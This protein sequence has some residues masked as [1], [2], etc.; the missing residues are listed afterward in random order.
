ME[1]KADSFALRR[2]PG[3]AQEGICLLSKFVLNWDAFL[4]SVC[5]LDEAFGAKRC[6]TA[7]PESGRIQFGQPRQPWR[8]SLLW[9][10]SLVHHPPLQSPLPHHPQKHTP[11]RTM[12]RPMSRKPSSGNLLTYLLTLSRQKPP[13]CPEELPS[14]SWPARETGC[15]SK[16]LSL[17]AGSLPISSSSQSLY[18]RLALWLQQRKC[19]F[20]CHRQ[21]RY[22]R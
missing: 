22:H 8:S 9:S 1:R 14:V 12:G 18:L 11:A 13:A 3:A 6:R 21:H 10:S 19:Q 2:P 16:S 20:C 7:N 5:G 4:T 17:L 15:K